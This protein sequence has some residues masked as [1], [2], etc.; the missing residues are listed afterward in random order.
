MGE[1]ERKGEEEGHLAGGLFVYVGV[2]EGEWAGGWV[3]GE[4]GE[5]W[6]C[7]CVSVS[8]MCGRRNNETKVSV[9]VHIYRYKLTVASLKKTFCAVVSVPFPTP[10]KTC[11]TTTTPTLPKGKPKL[12]RREAQ[13]QTVAKSRQPLSAPSLSINQ[14]PRG[15]KKMEE[16]AGRPERV[17]NVVL[18]IP[19]SRMRSGET[20]ERTVFGVC[21]CMCG[22]MGV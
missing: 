21:V 10:I 5:I 3:R 22:W 4:E 15:E 14:P 13:A 7:V 6:M 18:L 9:C 17:P 16:M 1:G 8:E 20:A 11:P 2:C 12:T 19:R